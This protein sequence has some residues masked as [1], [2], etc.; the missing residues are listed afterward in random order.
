MRMD[1]LEQYIERDLGRLSASE[2][3][4]IWRRRQ[5]S[6]HA[7]GARS[8][9][10]TVP[11]SGRTMTRAEAAEALGLTVGVYASLEVGDALLAPDER[12]R[13]RGAL[14]AMAPP[15]VGELCAVARRRGGG[16]LIEV[17][18]ALGVSRP[19]MIELERCGAAPVVA[20]WEK[21]GFR[22]PDECS[23]CR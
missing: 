19:R 15:T 8:R 2:R 4:W 23:Q 20:Y 7:R 5:T 1:T 10:S 21:R 13:V 16:G 12:E 22:F 17:E 11:R 18:R 3:L 9:Q 6:R 14:A